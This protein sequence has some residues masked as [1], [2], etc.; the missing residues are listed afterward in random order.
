MRISFS[1]ELVNLPFTRVQIK[2]GAGE[3]FVC[4]EEP[5]MLGFNTGYGFSPLAVG[6]TLNDGS[7]KIVGKLGWGQCSSVW[8]AKSTQWAFSLRRAFAPLTYIG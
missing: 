6:Q 8:L 5:H 2:E 1:E 7:Y 3:S 4:D